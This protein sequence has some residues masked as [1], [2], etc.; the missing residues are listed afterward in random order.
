MTSEVVLITACILQLIS[1]ILNGLG[2]YFLRRLPSSMSNQTMLLM[3][4]SLAEILLALS[5]TVW[6]LMFLCGIRSGFFLTVLAHGLS[7]YFYLVYLFTPFIIML[8]RFIG[9]MCPLKYV[10][11][12]AKSRARLIIIV[13]WILGLLLLVPRAFAGSYMAFGPFIALTIDLSVLGFA[14]PAFILMTFKIR[15]HKQRFSRSHIQ[16]RISTV[17]GLIIGSFV[18]LVLLPDIITSAL[19]NVSSSVIEVY[20]D[21]RRIY[22]ITC[23]NYIVDPIIYLYA[24]PPLRTVMKREIFKKGCSVPDPTLWQ[25][26]FDIGRDGTVST[27]PEQHLHL[28]TMTDQTTELSKGNQVSLNTRF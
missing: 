3:N 21:S 28:S 23:V 9:I 11:I 7:W 2:L 14:I 4:L 20:E 22:L 27:H 10:K 16:S 17:A 15:K 19:L 25:I 13:T 8:D 1:V 6:R 26:K 12:F 24:Y 18:F 5:A